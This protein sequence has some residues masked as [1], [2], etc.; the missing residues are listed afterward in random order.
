MS[1]GLVTDIPKYL[2]AVTSLKDNCNCEIAKLNLI[3]TNIIYLCLRL[4]LYTFS[5]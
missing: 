5:I 2:N 1:F 3:H 4:R